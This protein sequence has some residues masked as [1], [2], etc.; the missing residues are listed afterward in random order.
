MEEE[1]AAPS[2]S[3]CSSNVNS[4]KRIRLKVP[5]GLSS[6]CDRGELVIDRALLTNETCLFVMHVT[7]TFVSKRKA[8]G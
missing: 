4:E 6:S 7:L 1:G 2:P 5:A 8:R 3:M